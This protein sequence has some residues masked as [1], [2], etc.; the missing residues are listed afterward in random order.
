MDNL[1]G[2]IKLKYQWLSYSEAQDLVEKAISIFYALRY[3]CEPTASPET[4]PIDTFMD[5]QNVL[6]ICDEIAQRNGFNS[7]T[8]YRENGI[9]LEFD[10]AW[11]SDR[12]VN[13]II[14]VIGVI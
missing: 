3:P 13:T 10:G 2:K 7:A 8:G 1:V 4:R 14:P 11:V 5:K 6:W 12:I 9:S